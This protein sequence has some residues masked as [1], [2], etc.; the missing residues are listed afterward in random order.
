MQSE[1][2]TAPG[3]MVIAAALILTGVILILGNYISVLR[4]EKL[5]PLFLLLPVLILAEVLMNK[6]RKVE[7]VW[8][9]IV[10]LSTLSLYFLYLNFAGWN[11]VGLTWP[12][13][14]MIPGFGLL[15]LY[16][17]NRHPGILVPVYILLFTGAIFLGITLKNNLVSGVLFI[18]GGLFL[19]IKTFLHK[20][21]PQVR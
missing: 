4:I 20:K 19:V 11:M 13:F 18:A 8:V 2:R 16:L 10:I 3:A 21:Q 15:A 5:W 7:G 1:N 14:I 17:S 9:P 12:V 6:G